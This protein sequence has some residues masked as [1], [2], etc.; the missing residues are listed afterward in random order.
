MLTIQIKNWDNEVVA[1]INNIYSLEVNDEVNK[2]GKLK[3]KFPTEKWLQE[4]PLQKGYRISITYWLKIGKVIKLFEWY[5][6]DVIVKTT[7]VEI[8]AENWLS[9]LQYRMIRSDRTYTDQTIADVISAVYNELNTT[10]ELPVVLWLN[11]CQTK[12]TKDFSAGTSFYD[13]LKYCWTA[14]K[15]LICRIVDAGEYHFLECSENAGN[16]L[17]WVWEYDARNTVWTNITDWSWKDS[18]DQFY[19]YIQNEWGNINDDEFEENM[20]LIFEK[21]DSDWALKL[22][23]GIAIPSISISRDVDWWNFNPWDRKYV[24]LITGYDWLP[25]QYLWL[26]QSRKVNIT[27]S[28][29]IKAE[30]KISEEYKADTNIL[31]LVL[32]NL[33]GKKA[34]WNNQDMTNYYTKS[35]TTAIINTAVSW[36]AN[37]NHTHLVSQIT[38][39]AQAVSNLITEALTDY[40]TDSELNSAL[41]GKADSVHTHTVSDINWLETRLSGDESNI[42]DLQTEVNK[43][44][45]KSE[46]Y[47]KTEIDNKVETLEDSIDWKSDEGHTHQISDVNGLQTALEWKA[48][49]THTHGMSDISWLDTALNNKADKNNTYTK[50]ETDNLLSQKANSSHSHSMSDINWLSTELGNKADKTQIKNYAIT[51]D[52]VTV[53]KDSTKWVAPYSTSYGYTNI[54]INA[55]AGIEWKEWAIYTF[56]VNTEMVVASA[57][58]N[59]RVRIWNGDYIPVMWSSS[60]ILAGS[61]YFAK[62]QTRVFVYKTTYQSGGALHMINDTTYSTMSVAEWTTGTATTGRVM[63]ADYLK[64]IIQ[65]YIPTA[66][67]SFTNDTNFIT[68]AVNDLVNYYKKSETYTKTEVNNL[69]W[70][71]VWFT[72]EIVQTLPSTWSNWVM[73]LVPNGWGNPNSYDEYVWVASQNKFEK[74]WTTDMD[75]SNYIQKTDNLITINGVA[76]K[77]WESLT[78]PDTTYETLTA[79]IIQIGTET[80]GKLISAK[81]LKDALDNAVSWKADTVHTHEI[82][83]INGLSTALSGKANATHSHSISDITGLQTA[84]NWKASAVHSHEISDINW[85]S[86]ALSNKASSVHSHEIS[87]INWLQTALNGKANSSDIKDSTITFKINN[88]TFTGNSFTLNQ[89]EGK[90]INL[91][92]TKSTVWLGNVDNT[93]DANKPISTAVQEALNQK[94]NSVHSHTASQITDLSTV[95][96]DYLPLTWWTLTGNLTGLQGVF[97]LLK[98]TS[99]TELSSSPTKIAV[100]DSNGWISYRTLTHLKED[101]AIW[102]WRIWFLYDDE[103]IGYFITGQTTNKTI[104]IPKSSSQWEVTE[105]FV[106]TMIFAWVKD[107]D[108]VFRASSWLYRILNAMDENDNLWLTEWEVW[109][110]LVSSSTSMSMISHSFSVMTAIASSEIAMTELLSNNNAVKEVSECRNSIYII[111]SSSLARDMYLNSEYWINNL[112][113]YMPAMDAFFIDSSTKVYLINTYIMN[114]VNNNES[115]QMLYSDPVVESAI[116]NSTEAITAIAWS[117]DKL[118]IVKDDTV[119]RWAIVWN[120]DAIVLIASNTSRLNLMKWYSDIMNAIF[121]STT[122]DNAISDSDFVA[123]LSD[124]TLLDSMISWTASWQRIKTADEDMIIL[125]P[126]LSYTWLTG[127]NSFE[128]LSENESAIA[129]VEANQN[130]MKLINANDWAK[131]WISPEYLFEYTW[132]MQYTTIKIPW[133]YLI[134]CWWAWSN[135]ATWGYAEW[136]KVFAKNDKIAIVV[137]QSW[138]TTSWKT[139]WFWWSSNYGSDRAWGWLSGVFTGDTE[140]SSSDSARA[141]I[142][143]GWAWGWSGRGAG[144]AWGWE[145]WATWVSGWYG[146]VWGWG[147]QTWHWGSWNAWANQFNWWDGSWSYWYWGWGWRWW[148]NA[149]VW[150]RSGDDDKWAG[151]GSWYIWGVSSWS[152]TQWG[153]LWNTQHWK[154]QIIKQ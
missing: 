97:T 26:I 114:I 17:E 6:T 35:E 73:Y 59:V 39:F 66:L 85:L 92:V 16:V 118:D 11:D 144:W 29:G 49:S 2:W 32:T 119:I 75:L 27:A 55:N 86:E 143:A 23:S 131:S 146:T 91:P 62:T 47:T 140:V 130:A 98:T 89:S 43:K 28:W 154:V 121:E 135:T 83:D 41:S 105:N 145:N 112:F 150:D 99:A 134:K 15:N 141:L 128:Q 136:T 1:V 42:S 19:T 31:D 137:W 82:S 132:T 90:T 60:S 20:K 50:T 139:F 9:Y 74:I 3:I 24:R 120:N 142:I 65:H 77:F 18:M 58:R 45:N 129:I 110:D 103:E 101:L 4:K 80:V 44:A 123:L 12:I 88:A 5:I 111:A 95:L 147:T 79:Q 76:Y 84:L 37:I 54:D 115:L 68:N 51:E 71:I 52:I 67:S 34:G 7:E 57:N 125:P 152:M 14:N 78:T 149:S 108:N 22:P 25:L 63:R 116:S 33:R 151:W 48:N 104:V 10:S 94:A 13:I 21:F 56:V 46:V 113:N 70:Q 69:I 109:E 106:R 36:K 153:W 124:T 93:S 72:V 8:R 64:Q 53:T 38:D 122:A 30:V 87:E 127:I 81:L 107:F 61:S 133:T 40:V 148:G 102:W 100:L 138:S 117:Y 96:W 126:V